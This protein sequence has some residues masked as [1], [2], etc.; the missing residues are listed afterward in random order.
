MTELIK[1]LSTTFGPSGLEDRVADMIIEKLKGICDTV[2]LTPMG[3]V[4]GVIKGNGG[5]KKMISCAMDEAT[6][7]ISEIDGEGFIR[8]KSV[9]NYDGRALSGRAVTVGNETM[10]AP[11][12]KAVIFF[13]T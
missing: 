4:V 1:E 7:V 5:K 3:A 2:E 8:M 9:T 11:M 10:T 12:K 6:F 13:C